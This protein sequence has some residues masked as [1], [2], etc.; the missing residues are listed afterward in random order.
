MSI[1]ASLCGAIG[2]FATRGKD[3]CY[4]A[5]HFPKIAL[6]C[7]ELIS[8]KFV[9]PGYEQKCKEEKER[10]G[11]Y[12]KHAYDYTYQYR[13]FKKELDTVEELKEMLHFFN[14]VLLET[15]ELYQ[16]GTK[17][18]Q[19]W[20][21]WTQS[22]QQEEQ[23]KQDWKRLNESYKAQSKKTSSNPAKTESTEK[24]WARPGDTYRPNCLRYLGIYYNF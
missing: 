7:S 14:E 23:N 16:E 12:P 10:W 1:R 11:Q 21:K 15:L 6:I 4:T 24:R 8:N 17:R 5:Q 20:E 13:E 3:F 22:I 2:A 18:C 19:E 9:D